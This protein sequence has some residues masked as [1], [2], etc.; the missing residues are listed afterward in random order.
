MDKPRQNIEAEVLDLRCLRP[1]DTEAIAKTVAKT[2]HAVVIDEGWQTA[3]LSA[4]IMAQIMEQCFWQL[5]GPVQRVCSEEV[6]IPYPKHLEYAALPQVEDIVAAVNR[7]LMQPI[8][9]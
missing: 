3:G 4:E 9:S 1:L 8:H 7:A 6:P 5:D 2:R